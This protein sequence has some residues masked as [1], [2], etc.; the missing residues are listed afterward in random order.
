MVRAIP[1]ASHCTNGN[2]NELVGLGADPLSNTPG[3]LD[4]RI[5]RKQIDRPQIFLALW[6]PSRNLEAMAFPK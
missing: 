2:Q 6:F 4:F 1:G 3:R 5:G